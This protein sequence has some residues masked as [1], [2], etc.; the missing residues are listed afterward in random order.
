MKSSSLSAVNN[1]VT[2]SPALAPCRLSM[3]GSLSASKIYGLK[4][5]VLWVGRVVLLTVAAGSSRTA[6][7]EMPKI[8][9]LSSQGSVGIAGRG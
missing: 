3:A 4:V 1:P 5:M 2:S 6:R 7:A 9:P 8:A